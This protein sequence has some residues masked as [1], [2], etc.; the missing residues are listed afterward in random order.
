MSNTAEYYVAIPKFT[1]SGGLYSA[2]TGDSFRP[3]A[4]PTSSHLSTSRPSPGL[5]SKSDRPSLSFSNTVFE[6]YEGQYGR[7]SFVHRVVDG[8]MI[9]SPKKRSI[10]RS[11]RVYLSIDEAI[12]A[13]LALLEDFQRELEYSRQIIQNTIET[14]KLSESV[15]AYLEENL[16][17]FL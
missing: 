14:T 2:T 10:P 7:S 5:P 9:R 6:I 1:I 13:K 16:E 17:I 8:K 4:A 3:P 12:S 11:W 15:Q